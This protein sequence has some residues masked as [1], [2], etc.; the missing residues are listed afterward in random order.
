MLTGEHVDQVMAASGVKITKII[1]RAIRS[2]KLY[3][4]LM[5]QQWGVDRAHLW[6]KE[7]VGLPTSRAER[8][9]RFR[10]VPSGND[11]DRRH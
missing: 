4:T 5:Q 8:K 3:A 6:I 7:F 9:R 10:I 2:M 1:M 11:D